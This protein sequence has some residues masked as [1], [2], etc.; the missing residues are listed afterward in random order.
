VSLLSVVALNVV[1]SGNPI[2]TGVSVEIEVGESVGLIGE[3]GSGKSMFARAVFGLLPRGATS[4]GRIVFE[5][6]DL[7]NRSDRAYQK[8]RGNRIGYVPQDPSAAFNPTLRVAAQISEPLLFHRARAA[9]IGAPGPLQ[10]MRDVGLSDP[11]RRL[12]QYPHEMSG[13]MLQRTLIA[14]AVCLGPSLLIADEPTTG[15][16]VTTQ[17]GIMD[18]LCERQKA[19]GMALLLI[20]HDLALVSNVCSRIIVLYRGEIVESGTTAEVVGS[21]RHA[22][23]KALLEA[24]PDLHFSSAA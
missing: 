18:L 1:I 15:L 24:A 4:S 21:P 10:M 6:H 20:T 16:D 9:E 17:A 11:E 7:L 12:Q 14:S 5:A 22:Y 23:T 2:L 19:T 8:L 13:G 3:S